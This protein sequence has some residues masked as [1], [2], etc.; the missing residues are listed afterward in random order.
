MSTPT[1]LTRGTIITET[2]PTRFYR[3]IHIN[4]VEYLLL[5]LTAEHQGTTVTPGI[6]NY[7]KALEARP[8]T[9]QLTPW[10]GTPQPLTP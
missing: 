2:N 3:I 4:T 9:A 1:P 7:A 6:T 5:P 8:L 10:D